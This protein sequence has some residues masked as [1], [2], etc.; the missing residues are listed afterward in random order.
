MG[1]GRMRLRRNDKNQLYSQQ[2]IGV[3][4]VKGEGEISEE[5][6]QKLHHQRWLKEKMV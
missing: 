3:F 2:T 5:G 4:G 1:D 6:W